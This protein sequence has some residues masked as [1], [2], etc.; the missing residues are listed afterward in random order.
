M[1]NHLQ[2]LMGL[3]I[4]PSL[5]TPDDTPA[6]PAAQLA[7]GLRHRLA[8]A[9][10]LTRSVA[11]RLLLR[12]Y[13]DYTAH[14]ELEF[15]AKLPE[16]DPFVPTA[17]LVELQSSAIEWEGTNFV[18]SAAKAVQERRLDLRIQF[19]ASSERESVAGASDACELRVTIQTAKNVPPQQS[20]RIGWSCSFLDALEVPSGWEYDPLDHRA[21]RPTPRDDAQR[22]PWELGDK[23]SAY[24][25]L[26]RDVAL[27]NRQLFAS[28]EEAIASW[29]LWTPIVQHTERAVRSSPSSEQSPR[30]T[31]S[32]VEYATGSR[33]WFADDTPGSS[34]TAREPRD[35]L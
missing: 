30:H 22:L 32:F 10:S 1:I 2:L 6:D 14:Y 7:L 5:Q 23:E 3:A 17:A 25:V 27:G 33:L 19:G 20:Q 18:L 12:R 35:E 4:A 9:S 28:M 21:M 31:P 26:L 11:G 29:S 24:D 16:D 13:E 8:F 15:G 34:T